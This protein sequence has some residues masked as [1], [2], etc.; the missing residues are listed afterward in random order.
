MLLLDKMADRPGAANL[1]LAVVGVLYDWARDR[2]HVTNDPTKDIGRFK[3]GEHDPWPDWLVEEALNSNDRT[4][5]LAVHL[6]Y[7]TA[8]RIGDVCQMRWSDI[9]GGRLTV[10]Q[11]KTEKTLT[12]ACVTRSRVPRGL[13]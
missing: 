1:L 6:L 12:L 13:A 9:R 5:R 8:Q 3:I 7:F 10:Q 4:L 2:E 11:Q